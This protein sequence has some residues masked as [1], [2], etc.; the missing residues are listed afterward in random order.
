MIRYVPAPT[1]VEQEVPGVSHAPDPEITRNDDSGLEQVLDDIDKRIDGSQQRQQNSRQLTD[2]VERAVDNLNVSLTMI[3]LSQAMLPKEL[4]LE[5]PLVREPL[6]HESIGELD[7]GPPGDAGAFLGVDS[8]MPLSNED[9]RNRLLEEFPS[10][11]RPHVGGRFEDLDEVPLPEMVL[12]PPPPG[13]GIAFSTPISG[14]PTAAVRR[15][16]DR[17]GRL[18]NTDLSAIKGPTTRDM[19]AP[20]TEDDMHVQV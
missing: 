7:L 18:Y 9:V 6:V 8:P 15:I 16:P 20:P 12:M 3:D 1:A 19:V 10:L 2:E 13:T 5:E 17:F 14:I 4:L 11:R